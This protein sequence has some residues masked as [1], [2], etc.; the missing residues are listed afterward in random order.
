LLSDRG[1]WRLDEE[2][3]Y[4]VIIDDV[5]HQGWLLMPCLLC[6]LLAELLWL[7]RIS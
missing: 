3:V 2:V 4:V 1:H 7:G 6:L 5:S